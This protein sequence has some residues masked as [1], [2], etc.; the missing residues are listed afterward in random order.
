MSSP[1]FSTSADQTY[2]DVVTLGGSTSITGGSI[3]FMQTVDSD[4]A[5][6]LRSLG[7]VGTSLNLFNGVVGGI[8]PLSTLTTD[9]TGATCFNGASVNTSSNQTYKN[10]VIIGAVI[11]FNSTGGGV[12]FS[13]NVH[14]E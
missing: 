2:N 10:P 13:G 6:S 4:S 12:G 8:F 1:A 9:T 11:T 3:S 5:S 7:F 14:S